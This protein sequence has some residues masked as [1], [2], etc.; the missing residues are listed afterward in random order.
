VNDPAT[1]TYQGKVRVGSR[2]LDLFAASGVLGVGSRGNDTPD[3][4]KPVVLS[5]CLASPANRVPAVFDFSGL[6]YRWGDY[7]VSFFVILFRAG[8]MPA[9]IAT[10]ETRAALKTLNALSLRVPL[11]SSLDEID[12]FD[13]T[14]WKYF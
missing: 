7:L 12:K 13:F 14:A 5:A 1:L 11:F 2:N 3:R 6:E 8:I 10:G 4:W 9:I